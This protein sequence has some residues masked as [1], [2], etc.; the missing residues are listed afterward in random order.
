MGNVKRKLGLAGLLLAGITVLFPK[1]VNAQDN[2]PIDD[3]GKATTKN[4]T[5]TVPSIRNVPNIDGKSYVGVPFTYEILDF[6]ARRADEPQT[7]FFPRFFYDVD[8]DGKWG[9][10]EEAM[11][12]AGIPMYMS[13]DFTKKFLEAY[14]KQD[15][16]KLSEYAK[17]IDELEK[18]IKE[19]SGQ[20]QISLEPKQKTKTQGVPTKT[21]SVTPV[22]LVFG[23]N[24]NFA[25]NTFGGS[26]GIRVNSPKNKNFGLTALLDINGG[27]DQQTGSTSVTYHDDVFNSDITMSGTKTNTN[28]FSIGG[29]LEINYSPF[30][31]GGGANYNS[32]IENTKEQVSLGNTIL[33]SNAL[34][35]TNSTISGKVYAGLELPIGDNYKLGAITGYDSRN[36]FYF[37]L[38]N[39]IRL[40]PSKE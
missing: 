9:A 23:G 26:L 3:S 15:K 32:W 13:D 34:S 22:S 19:L 4:T 21:T 31:L 16:E 39:A 35:V 2:K 1:A 10:A 40:N 8:N 29:S 12:K 20:I 11:E 17:Q 25:F 7:Q 33:K 28:N 6:Y 27:L 14:R 24:S 18:R 37:G 30:V 36:G 38:R 5:I